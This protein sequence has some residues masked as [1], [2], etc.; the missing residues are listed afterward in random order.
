MLLSMICI[1]IF[2]ILSTK[3]KRNWI[4]YFMHATR[5][6]RETIVI[7]NDAFDKEPTS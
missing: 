2:N 3:I 7:R 6:T 5:S 1:K 4:H